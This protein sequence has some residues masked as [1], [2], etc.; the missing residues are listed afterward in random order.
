[1]EW[2][3]IVILTIAGGAGWVSYAA[4]PQ[5]VNQYNIQN[6]TSIQNQGQ[7]TIVDQRR[8]QGVQFLVTNI[9]EPG[10]FLDGLEE[11]QRRELKIAGDS[12][13]GFLIVYPVTSFV[14][15]TNFSSYTNRTNY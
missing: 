10:A 6:Q 3:I 5:E 9:P 11:W 13:A 7:A 4:K 2:I 15:H 1:M 8:L 12:R 14:S